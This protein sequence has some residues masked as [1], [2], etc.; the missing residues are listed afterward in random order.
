MHEPRNM[1]RNMPSSSALKTT[2]SA[3]SAVRSTPVYSSGSSSAIPIASARSIDTSVAAS[4]KHE[5]AIDARMSVAAL[6]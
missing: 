6:Q 1:P 4:L 5:H 3:C 2:D